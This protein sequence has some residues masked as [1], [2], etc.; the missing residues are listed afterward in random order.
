[1]AKKRGNTKGAKKANKDLQIG[2]LI[3]DRREELGIP[4][5]D[6]AEGMGVSPQ[7][8]SKYELSKDSV[9]A[10]TLYDIAKMLKAPI[11]S[12]FRTRK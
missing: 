1:M 9:H 7:Q 11:E 8:L 3:R 10:H 2:K 5:K 12:F 6:L 4:M